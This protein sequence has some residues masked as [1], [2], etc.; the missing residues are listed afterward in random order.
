MKK[1]QDPIL[2]ELGE[3][4]REQAMKRYE[5][6]AHL[7]GQNRVDTAEWEAAAK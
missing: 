4:E 7:L 2:S 6:I 1:Q 5:L 3:A